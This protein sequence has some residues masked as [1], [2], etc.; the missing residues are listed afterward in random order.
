[1][2]YDSMN[3]IDLKNVTVKSVYV[4]NVLDKYGESISDHRGIKANLSLE[5]SFQNK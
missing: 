3:E 2:S 4:E 1:M 5:K